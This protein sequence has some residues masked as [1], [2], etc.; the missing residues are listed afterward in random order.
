VDWFSL[1]GGAVIGA[2][3]GVLVQNIAF[4]T[5][6]QWIEK[7]RKMR[8]YSK[9]DQ[10]WDSVDRQQLNLRLV[11]AGWDPDGYF[12]PGTV[13]L[14]LRGAFTLTHDP[15]QQ[16]RA[17]HA[18]AWLAQKY[19]DE[20]QVGITSFQ[21]VRI[22]DSPADEMS[23]RAHRLELVTHTYRY[24]DYL[25]THDLLRECTGTEREAL[26]SV[27]GEPSA[28]EP[29]AGFPNPCSVGVS[30]FCEDGA[31]LVMTQRSKHSSGGKYLGEKIFNAVGENAATRDFTVDLDGSRHTVPEQVASRGLHQE[32]GFSSN[33]IQSCT[34]IGI[35]S[36]AW[37]TELLDHKFFGLAVTPLARR[38]VEYRLRA[39][40]D[41]LAESTGVQFRPVATKQQCVGL[42]QE[43]KRNRDSWSPEAVFSSVRS[44]LIL[45]RI[46]PSDLTE[47]FGAR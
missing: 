34:K 42:L 5:F 32:A 45:R 4:P 30:L 39:A 26:A 33:D 2:V 27:I 47:V 11:Q 8:F 23:G 16:I 28:N 44:L 24:F 22:S 31:Y 20:E 29:V 36:F 14:L 46:R 40:K 21:A 25:A 35:H 7:R 10:V 37:S 41:F 38:E 19:T 3:F 12:A 15:L 6:S 43:I 13:R 18:D 1:I 9:V 17:S